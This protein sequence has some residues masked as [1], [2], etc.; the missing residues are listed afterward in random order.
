VGQGRPRY[1]IDFKGG[2]LV[3]VKFAE[4]PELDRLRPTWPSRA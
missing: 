4:A 3:Y 1:G 2:T